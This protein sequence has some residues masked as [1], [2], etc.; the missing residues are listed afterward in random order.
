MAVFYVVVFSSL[1]DE[2]EYKRVAEPTE[3]TR[4][5]LENNLHMI[6]LTD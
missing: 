4:P 2:M 3:A 1:R 6:I 5:C